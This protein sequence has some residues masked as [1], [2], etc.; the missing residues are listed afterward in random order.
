MSVRTELYQ[1]MP[2]PGPLA[3]EA[4]LGILRDVADHRAPYERTALSLGF[5]QIR[6]P[7]AGVIAVPVSID[8]R[9]QPQ[10]YECELTISATAGTKMFP[11]FAGSLSVSPMR[12]SGSE[13]WLAGTYTVPLG[14]IGEFVD[15]TFL[16]GAADASLKRFVVWFAE[17][18]VARVNREQRAELQDR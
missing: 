12:D 5:D 3:L 15:A 16:H 13:L 1:A 10:R 4:M 6:L 7:A 2:V 14:A 11:K 8:T 18:I 17:Q 9:T